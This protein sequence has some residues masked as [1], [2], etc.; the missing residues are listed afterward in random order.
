MSLL[1]NNN[2]GFKTH[3]RHGEDVTAKQ[4]LDVTES[5]NQQVACSS[6]KNQQR[7]PN[8]TFPQYKQRSTSHTC[9]TS[10][11]NEVKAAL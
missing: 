9:H 8:N 1:K 6:I 11:H 4:K 10:D 3:R 2:P 5:W 7:I